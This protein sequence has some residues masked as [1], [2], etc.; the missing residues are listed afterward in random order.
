MNP[1]LKTRGE[2][3]NHTNDTNKAEKQ[4]ER[5]RKKGTEELDLFLS[6]VFVY[7]V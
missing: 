3:T 5:E 2:T 1:L 6:V 4:T 7:F